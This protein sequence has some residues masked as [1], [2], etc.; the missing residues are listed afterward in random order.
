MPKL[1]QKKTQ[2]VRFTPPTDTVYALSDL[3]KGGRY[4]RKGEPLHRDDEMV[5][6]LPSEFEVRYPLALECSEEVNDGR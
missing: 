1:R 4:V 6:E 5:R 2:P 3:I